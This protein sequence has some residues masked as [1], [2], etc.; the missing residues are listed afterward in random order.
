M[1]LIASTHTE[2]YGRVEELT[3]C[4]FCID[5]DGL[6]VA[7]FKECSGLNGEVEVET[8]QEGGLNDYEHKLP[9][10]TKFGNVTLRS[11]VASSIDLWDW[12]HSV[13][14]GQVTGRAQ[15]RDVS[16]VMYLQDAGEAMRWNLRAAYPVRWQ[17]PDFSAGDTNV[18]LHSLELAHHGIELSQG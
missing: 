8:Y 14:T 12:F 16:I 10:R 15:R 3:A 1:P 11:G 7:I 5:V 18:A 2:P 17:G 6:L 9:G 4:R 13:S